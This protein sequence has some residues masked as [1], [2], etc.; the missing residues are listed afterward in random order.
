MKSDDPDATSPDGDEEGANVPDGPDSPE[1]SR[2]FERF[3]I[4]EL[5]GKGAF[6]EVYLAVDPLLERKVALKIVRI[7]NEAGVGSPLPL[8]EIRTLAKLEHRG[9]V[10]IFEAG[11][12]GD[13]RFFF[14]SKYLEGPTLA[15]LIR[16]EGLQRPARAAEVVRDLAEALEY[17][18][19]EGV[20]H[21][22]VKP[23]NVILSKSSEGRPVLIDFGVAEVGRSVEGEHDPQIVGTPGYLSPEQ[24]RG[25]SHLV[26]ARSD[27]F[28]L[29][30]VLYELL[31]GVRP[32]DGGADTLVDTAASLIEDAPPLR[33]R[34][35]DVPKALERICL[36]MLSKRPIDRYRSAE[37]VAEELRLFLKNVDKDPITE[38]RKAA[39]AQLVPK[40]LRSFNEEDADFFLRLLPG[41]RDQLG[42]PS[43]LRFWLRGISETRDPFR[44][45]VLY[46]PSGSG[47]SSF[48]QA[49]L[50]PRVPEWVETVFVPAGAGDLVSL[51][52]E[53]I[54]AQVPGLRKEIG[55][56]E[57]KQQV[58]HD[59]TAFLKMALS[60]E[61]EPSEEGE[62]EDEEGRDRRNLHEV[63]HILRH[64]REGAGLPTE[65]RLLI[66]IDQFEQW[67]HRRGD[68]EQEAE[69]I[70]ALRQADGNRVQV[71]L[72]VRDDF[73]MAVADLM[74]DLDVE[75][76][77]TRNADAMDLFDRKH[78]RAVLTEFGRAYDRLPAEGELPAG[79]KAFIEAAMSD[80]E[81]DEGRILPLQLAS[82]AEMARDLA[83]EEG[84][85]RAMGGAK[86]VGVAFLESMLSRNRSNPAYR[87]IEEPAKAILK[88]LLP[89]GGGP[90]KSRPLTAAELREKA[91]LEA[92]PERFE[93]TLE[94]LD[95]ELRLVT[96]FDIESTSMDPEATDE[97]E[98][99][100]ADGDIRCYQLS[101]DY[102]VPALRAWLY[103][104]D[105]ATWRGRSRLRLQELA[106]A[107]KRDPDSRHL[108]TF[109]EW[110]KIHL[111]VR[112]QRWSPGES[113]VMA[114]AGRHH[115]RS[116]GLAL[117]LLAISAVLIGWQSS[118]LSLEN[119][120]DEVLRVRTADLPAIRERYQALDEGIVRK[121]ETRFEEG[122]IPE[123][124]MLN[125]RLVLSESQPGH[126]AFLLNSLRSA[127][128]VATEVIGKALSPRWQEV[129]ADAWTILEDTNSSGS[130]KLRIATFLARVRADQKRWTEFAPGLAR[131][132]LAAPESETESWAEMLRPLK[133]WVVPHLRYEFELKTDP[134]DSRRLHLALTNLFSDEVGELRWMLYQSR[135]SELSIVANRLDQFVESERPLYLEELQE[136]L[137]MFEEGFDADRI[138]CVEGA[139]RAAMLLRWQGKEG[140]PSSPVWRLFDFLPV[141]TLR[142]YLIETAAPMGVAPEIL[143]AHA[144]LE[145][146]SATRRQGLLLALGQFGAAELDPEVKHEIL[147]WLLTTFREDADPGVHASAHWLLGEWGAAIPE[148]EFD[149]WDAPPERR[150]TR[151][152]L[153]MEFSVIEIP[154]GASYPKELP[155]RFSVG[156]REV[157]NRDFVRAGMNLSH[158]TT[159]EVLEEAPV[160]ILSIREIMEF[161]NRVSEIDGIPEQEWCYE[162]NEAG[163]LEPA[164]NFLFRRGYR[165]GDLMENR[166]AGL[167]GAKTERFFGS[168]V[169]LLDRYAWVTWKVEEPRK[170]TSRVGLLKPNENGLFDILGNISEYCHVYFA[171]MD[172]GRIKVKVVGGSAFD[173]PVEAVHPLRATLFSELAYSRPSTSRIG[174]RLY[175]ALPDP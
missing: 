164:P 28:G 29:G 84:E 78:S 151:N 133:E 7:S 8:D 155:R 57:L 126:G 116:F 114:E 25:E 131:W 129:E 32:F 38:S 87:G 75:L 141:P 99:S 1:E 53:R 106:S 119:R 23:G 154:P 156:Q 136:D 26:D 94:I 174:I 168:S 171:E 127:D 17:A 143:Y 170:L 118:E 9:I 115:L 82:F 19:G 71:I 146:T 13:G 59:P 95:R 41:V 62:D 48:L 76:L 80:M 43:G 113:A 16:E 34:A 20:I 135:D 173:P 31:T 44:I 61:P 66:V 148:L 2:G 107:W 35:P 150:W 153:G 27:I 79:T 169:E 157:T 74:S 101:H 51:L 4:G 97:S 120:T 60:A 89:E 162:M 134:R 39:R 144:A 73:W 68:R 117:L 46:G 24:A 137:R 86:A 42:I 145:E 108:P 40:G 166:W 122:V 132:L 47:K 152:H 21:R 123:R 58:H 165:L 50:L 142:S 139:R 121:V 81:N 65:H 36:K 92:Q 149:S 11:S 138:F 10:P 105:R 90:L 64:L 140:D 102:L 172:G 158:Y 96:P 30:V 103:E 15:E 159:E 85:Y 45:G 91:F 72:S 37:E 3:E 111:G 63:T 69:L 124:E 5:L 33:R 77:Q 22:D 160:S 98:E 104:S 109:V 161:A 128:V 163:N 54:L 167:A 18:H 110:T 130:E 112:K 14:A 55:R 83:W 67:L 49:G 175:R 147:H 88:A 6:G 100:E 93:Q 52:R 70:R 125:A 12:A 56:E